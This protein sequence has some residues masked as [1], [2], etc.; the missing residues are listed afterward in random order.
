MEII[1]AENAG[2]C[3]GVN[4][5]VEKTLNELEDKTKETYSYGPLIHNNQVVKDLESKGLNTIDNINNINNI[6]NGKIIIRSHGVPKDVSKEIFDLNLELVD[7]TCPYVISIHKKVE[8]FNKKGYDI[9]II[10]DKNHPEIIGINSFC[11]N[12]AYIINSEDEACELPNLDKV[13]LVSQTTNTV[14]K[15]NKLAE[16]VKSKSNNIEV[17]NTICNATKI[18]QE[19]ALKVAKMVNA[20]IVIGGKHS[21]NTQKLVEISKKYCDN[22]YHIETIKDL[23]L[24]DIQKFNKIG[25]TA[26]ASTPDWLIK[27]AILT[28][29]NNLNKDEMM[30]AIESSF[31]R[32]RRGDII[33]GTILYVTENELMVNI[34]YKSDG[35]VAK[36]EASHDDD[37]NL[38]ETYKV[39]DEIDVY[40][41]KLDDGEGNVVL[42]IKKV[43]DLKVWDV[44][45]EDFNN[46]E[47]IECKINNV[48]KG[49]L[50]VLVK[51]INGFMPASHVSVN[52]VSKLDD[53]KGKKLMV[54]II[55]IDRHKKRI[56]LSRKEVERDELEVKKAELWESLKIDD[57]VTGVVQR[58]TDF[59]AF[60]DLGGADGLIHISDL[61]WLRVKHPSDVLKVGDNVEVKV[62]ALD[63][64]RNR[65]SLGL[66]QTLE[67]PW[68][69]FKEN[70]HE[71]D[72]VEG[73]VV[74]L[75]DFG[76]FI[77]LKEGVD[78]L[79]HVSQISKEHV[80]KPSDV[81][82]AG[83]I[84]TVKVIEI[85][86]EDRRISLSAKD[87]NPDEE[88]VENQN[89]NDEI[90]K[91]EELDTT[92]GDIINNNK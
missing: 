19:S 25:I 40:V 68:S 34:N 79:L 77:R 78:G 5:A 51:G 64:E 85:N 13:C 76:A 44:L 45:E 49:G 12:M 92:V 82:K 31:T 39:G 55:D 70:V 56:I 43:D 52:Y 53:F 81:L 30:E 7:C 33:K 8:Q 87:V 6:K 22:V 57:I 86:D 48:V 18:R 75:L 61:S 21:S 24:Q 71:G 3:F 9:V 66:K 63:K 69:V 23:S 65:I 10:G 80:N 67:E 2:F 91:N 37:I 35:I 74:N 83:D 41:V 60:V 4:R 36:S 14:E 50:T 46:K 47:T 58:L 26:G 42:S 38:K 16:I 32:I 15:F 54:K 73:K 72:I 29:E 28:M 20:M 1:I 59:G 89:E 90:I 88:V 27:E 62:L 17:F 11:D 84:V